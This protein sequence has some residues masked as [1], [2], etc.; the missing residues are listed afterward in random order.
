[1]QS[2][3]I[4]ENIFYG[5]VKGDNGNFDHVRSKYFINDVNHLVRNKPAQ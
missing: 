3:S 5:F 4:D 2:A 1:M